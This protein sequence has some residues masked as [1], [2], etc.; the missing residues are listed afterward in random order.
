M[1][2]GSLVI[3]LVAGG[4]GL[5]RLGQERARL[6]NVR[7]I[8]AAGAAPRAPLMVGN[9]AFTGSE[10]SQAIMRFANLLRQSAATQH[11][12]IE[13]IEILPKQAT[14]PAVM[15]T[16]IAA[17][18]SERNVRIYARA[19]ETGSPVVRFDHWR[20]VRTGDAEATIRIEGRAVALWAGS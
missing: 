18:G 16:Y 9:A 4:L 3:S 10:R 2:A 5:H 12:L 8:A 20:L 7:A 11:L 15:I 14:A 17:S 19:L 1:L 13:K 6:A